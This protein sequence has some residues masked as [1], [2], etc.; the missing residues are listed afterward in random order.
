MAGMIAL[1]EPIVNLLF[2]RGVWDYAATLGTAESLMYYSFGLWAFM[3]VRVAAP[4]FYSMQDTRTPVKAGV[5]A[6]IA[7]VVL[8]LALMGPLKHSGLAL[9]NA[10]SAMLNFVMLMY[11]LRKKLQWIEGRRILR[12]F[13]KSAFASTVMGALAWTALR[14]ELWTMPGDAALKTILMLGVIAVSALLYV[15]ISR[16]LGCEELDFLVKRFLKKER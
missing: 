9:A 4:A 12:S 2:Q 10:L 13:L 11:L 7:N 14:Q 5:A 16:V 8:S 3:G 1:K 6:L 15:I